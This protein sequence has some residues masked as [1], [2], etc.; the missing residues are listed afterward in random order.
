M[1]L[2]LAQPNLINLFMIKPIPERCLPPETTMTLNPLLII[3]NFQVR[4]PERSEGS[5]IY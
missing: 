3:R 5:L 2:S 4:H 1:P